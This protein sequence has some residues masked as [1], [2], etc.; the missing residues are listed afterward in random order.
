VKERGQ[1]QQQ[2]VQDTER[3]CKRKVVHVVEV[4][5]EEKKRGKEEKLKRKR[6]VQ[7]KPEIVDD[8]G[9]EEIK[10]EERKHRRKLMMERK[11]AAT[12]EEKEVCS[13]HLLLSS[14]SLILSAC[15][16]SVLYLYLPALFCLPADCC[17][18]SR[19]VK[20]SDRWRRRD[21]VNASERG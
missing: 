1:K 13:I 21:G 18:S 19:S 9:G 20:F 5:Q 11:K 14:Y 15:L 16:L 2:L 7:K 3:E 17:L 8:E 12:I 6:L 10:R 4:E